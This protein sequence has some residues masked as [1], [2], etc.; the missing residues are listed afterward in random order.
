MVNSW[1]EFHRYVSASLREMARKGDLSS[2]DTKDALGE[3]WLAALTKR[4]QFGG[5]DIERQLYA[6]MRGVMRHKIVDFH[7]RRHVVSLENLTREP[8]AVTEEEDETERRAWLHEKLVAMASEE[9]T[10]ARLFCGHFRD[11]RTLAELA[12]EEELSEKAVESRIV[13]GIKKL[14]RIATKDG[15]ASTDEH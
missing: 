13:R 9:E 4:P 2:E 11:G 6:W 12:A 10:N 1:E 8:A 14:R 15:L 7:R 5:K 3:T